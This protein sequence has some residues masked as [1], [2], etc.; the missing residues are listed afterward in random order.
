MGKIEKTSADLG[1]P[2]FLETKFF[3]RAN[4]HKGAAMSFSFPNDDYKFQHD[5]NDVVQKLPPPSLAGGTKR[6]SAKHIL[7]VDLSCYDPI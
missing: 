3:R 4:L 6:C 5:Q 7:P 2:G 1:K